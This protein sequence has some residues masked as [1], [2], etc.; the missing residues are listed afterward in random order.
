MLEQ[1]TPQLEE[2][3]GRM[4]RPIPGQSLTEAPDTSQPYV[5]S[6]EFTVIQEAI[7]YIF[8]TVTEEETYENVMSSIARGVSIME[9]TQLL[10]F[11]GFNEGKWNPDLMLLLAEPTAYMLMG[12]A[13]RAGIDY[14]ITDEDDDEINV[15]GTALPQERAEQLESKEIPEET[16][17]QLDNTDLPSLMGK[18]TPSLMQRQ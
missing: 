14:K 13:E 10:L 17:E 11:A 18:P 4:D 12:L 8:V 6:P 5:S 7:D 15:F 1:P 2:Y 3:Q 16:V 9:I